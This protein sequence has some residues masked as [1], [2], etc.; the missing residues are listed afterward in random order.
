M[1]ISTL[2][3]SRTGRNYAPNR[4]LFCRVRL[5]QN[6]LVVRQSFVKVWIGIVPLNKQRPRPLFPKGNLVICIMIMEEEEEENTNNSVAVQNEPEEDEVVLESDSKL[7]GNRITD[8]A[9]LNERISSQLVCGFYHGSVIELK[10]QGLDSELAFHCSSRQC[11]EH[12]SF[13]TSDQISVGNLSISSVN[14][15]S[16]FAIRTI[17]CGTLFVLWCHGSTT[18]ST[19]NLLPQ[20]QRHN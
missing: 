10:K 18:P 8:M 9:I 13:H 19:E 4:A 7:E 15:R 20:N 11:N 2:R 3:G 1:A 16:V 5:G 14:R 12:S 6:V 17:G